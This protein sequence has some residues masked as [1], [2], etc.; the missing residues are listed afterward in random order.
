M[1]LLLLIIVFPFGNIL[2]QTISPRVFA[3]DS[4]KTGIDRYWVLLRTHKEAL[5]NN[6]QVDYSGINELHIEIPSNGV[7]IPLGETTDFKGLRLHVKNKSKSLFLF[8]LSQDLK[9][10]N[11]S[12]EDFISYTFSNYYSIC[13]GG[14]VLVVEDM[15]PWVKERIGYNYGSI[16]KDILMI[17]DG[18]LVNLPIF[19]YVSLDS[20]P[21]FF[22]YKLTNSEKTI[23]NL[24]IIR[25]EDSSFKTFCFLIKNQDSCTMR[26]I[27]IRTP[28][29]HLFGDEAIAIYNSTRILLDNILIDGTY[30][31][32]SKYGYG[33][34]LN[35]VWNITI[36]RMKATADWGVFGSFNVNQISIK[37]SDIN[38]FDIHCYGKDV[39]FENCRITGLYNQYSSVYGSI[40]HSN[41]VFDNATPCLI[42]GSYNAYTPFDLVFEDCIFKLNKSKNTIVS[43]YAF[44][45]LKNQRTEL[46]Q[47]CLPN[48]IMKRCSIQY[49][50][51][52]K[53]WYVFNASKKI[54]YFDIIEY[55]SE[56][57]IDRLCL[58][59]DKVEFKPFNINLRTR[60]TLKLKFKRWK[61][62]L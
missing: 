22:Y 62:K 36:S 20:R 28:D 48:V 11:I 44:S 55:L 49:S 60:K 25:T 13:Y 29:S 23:Q 19:N 57:D 1:R 58:S 53:E 17:N 33:I 7:S 40:R 39:Q 3:L 34:S 30:S 46:S 42:E 10:I 27:I 56:I 45:N 38:R 54:E 50:S 9:R 24:E 47:K 43:L 52:L 35:N 16:R 41:C 59:S 61:Y 51:P 6:L 21:R 8:N 14:Y 31:Q 37:D 12:K 18:H 4:A 26:N 5:K 2:S 32:K 15:T